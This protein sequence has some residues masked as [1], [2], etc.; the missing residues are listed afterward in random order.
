MGDIEFSVGIV[1]DYGVGKSTLTI[2]FVEG[3][4]AEYDP[5]EIIYTM[6][7]DEGETVHL[8][9][10]DSPP[11]REHYYYS[12]WTNFFLHSEVFIGKQSL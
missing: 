5:T 9:I 12:Q 11:A 3:P 8:S 1:G 4:F 6:Q 7:V 10:L 2:R